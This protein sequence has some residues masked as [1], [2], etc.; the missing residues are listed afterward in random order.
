MILNR[1]YSEKKISATL[2]KRSIIK[3]LLNACNE[4]AF[5]FNKKMYEKIDGVSR[6]LL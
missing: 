6:D 4:T 2:S 1:V 5:S 3:L